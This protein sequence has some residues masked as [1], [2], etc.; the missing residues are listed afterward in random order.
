MFGSNVLRVFFNGFRSVWVYVFLNGAVDLCTVGLCTMISLPGASR[1]IPEGSTPS[2]H[3]NENALEFPCPFPDGVDRHVWDAEWAFDA[4]KYDGFVFEYTLENPG[5]FRGVTVF[6]RSGSGWLAAGLPVADGAQRI[7]VPTSAFEAQNDP[8]GWHQLD[9]IR[10]S[11]WR[12]GRGQGAVHV[13]NLRAVTSRVAVLIPGERSSENPRERDFG[14]R[15]AGQW[16]EDL[17]RL[18]IFAIPVEEEALSS[19][20]AVSQGLLILP[21]NPAPP[22]SMIRQLQAFVRDGGKLLVSYNANPALAE[23]VG[24]R[25]NR[26][27]SG[28]NGAFHTYRFDSDGWN[29]PKTLAQ[30]ATPHLISIRP[31][32]TK[33]E[34]LAEWVNAN[35]DSASEPAVLWGD[36]GVWFSYLLGPEDDETRLEMLAFL[37]DRYEPGLALRAARRRFEELAGAVVAKRG[38]T[39]KAFETQRLAAVEALA[40]EDAA[41]AWRL[42]SDLARTVERELADQLRL[43]NDTR[44]A[45]W[46]HTGRGLY[47]GDWARTLEDLAS[48]GIQDVFVHV[49]RQHREPVEAVRAARS[50]KVRIH[51]WHV[52]YNLEGET[53]ERIAALDREQR[54]QRSLNGETTL[55][56]CPSH[57]EN[58]RSE[59]ERLL[60]LAQ[61][62]GLAGLH[63]DYIRYPDERHC[64]CTGCRERFEADQG[65][66]VVTWPEDVYGGIHAERYRN[67]RARKI[68]DL[69][70]AVSRKVKARHGNLI[71][72]V[73]VWPDYP[74]VKDTLGQDW[75]EWAEKGWVDLITTM[76]YTQSV[77]ELADWTRRHRQLAGDDVILWTGLGVTS[78]H[79]RLTPVQTFGQS[80]AAL[81]TGA[82]GVV[83]FDLNPTVQAGL[84]PLMREQFSGDAP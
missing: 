23:L 59:T 2:A 7:W 46:D 74:A 20:R 41:N 60:S 26:W 67:W 17:S 62:R 51:A 75:G 15:N 33:T 72:S 84:L 34:V 10:L 36:H 45:I 44:F 4:S 61:T 54:L 63:L 71:F 8:A 66:A 25:V 64:F 76:S 69:V 24:V 38:E 68:S 70:E 30:P 14:R 9:G 79:S 31:A 22:V 39:L 80:K 48:A 57:P 81:E 19:V 52:C 56:L 3:M 16:I 18:D 83:I 1:W 55:W 6:F 47:P 35:G 13:Q 28:E 37:L 12:A 65:L 82:D 50:R 42:T 43:P 49:G 11:P 53:A 29:G 77:G 40:R 32:G 78:S 73:A 27:L 5:A 58:Q 21:Y